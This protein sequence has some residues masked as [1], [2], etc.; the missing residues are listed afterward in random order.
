MPRI[1]LGKKQQAVL[2]YVAF[3]PGCTVAEA[4]DFFD[5]VFKT[6]QAVLNRLTEKGLVIKRRSVKNK[7]EFF[8]TELGMRETEAL[9]E[10]ATIDTVRAMY[11]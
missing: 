3:R 1:T 6:I 10:V 8:M 9:R 5:R 7:N 2:L 11:E 4:T